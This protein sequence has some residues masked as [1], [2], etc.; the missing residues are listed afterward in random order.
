MAWAEIF[1]NNV[2]HL[3]I[4]LISI[5]LYFQWTADYKTEYVV[6]TTA[7][8]HDLDSLAETCLRCCCCCWCCSRNRTTAH[9]AHWPLFAPR[10]VVYGDLCVH[11]CPIHNNSL[12]R[13]R[14]NSKQN[15]RSVLERFSRHHDFTYAPQN[16]HMYTIIAFRI[17]H[18]RRLCI[19]S[20]EY[21]Y[22]FP[23]CL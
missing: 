4:R 5:V 3:I 10:N 11:H 20:I 6:V 8:S 14:K 1:T 23:L 9:K 13:T 2:I 22:S 12:N 19:S 18:R 7:R 16:G 17:I 21:L 15:E